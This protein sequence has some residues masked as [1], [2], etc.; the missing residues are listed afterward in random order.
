MDGCRLMVFQLDDILCIEEQPEDGLETDAFKYDRG[1][2]PYLILDYF[3]D[4]LVGF[5][6]TSSAQFQPVVESD[7][8]KDRC[9]FQLHLYKDTN[10]KDGI[11]VAFSVHVEN[12]TYHMY[13]TKDKSIQFREGTPPK[14]IPSNG[15]DLIF[16][17]RVFSG[18][19][20]NIFKFESSLVKGGYLARESG[21]R[22]LFLKEA[23][24]QV[25]EACHLKLDKRS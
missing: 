10:G 13:C 14:S 21:S 23:Q 12:K 5:P 15:S 4:T 6:E 16:Y 7:S 11:A 9:K 8:K 2:L 20:S 3:N 24:D 17:Q 25:D 18:S 1:S 22:R 19:S